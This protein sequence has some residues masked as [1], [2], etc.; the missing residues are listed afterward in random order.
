M[1]E[2]KWASLGM[3]LSETLRC[4]E[5][6]MRAGR[7][8]QVLAVAGRH[9]A[10]CL[11]PIGRR[12]VSGGES[13]PTAGQVVAEQLRDALAE[14]GPTFIKLGQVLSSRPDLLP[15]AFEATLSTLQDSAPAV[16]FEA[17]GAAVRAELGLSPEEVFSCFGH[18]PLAAASI[19]QVHPARLQ[20]GRQVVVKVRRPGVEAL[21]ELDLTILRRLA[22]LASSFPGPAE[23][24]NVAGF[25]EEFGNTTRAELDYL[26][27][28]HNEDRARPQLAPLGVHVPEVVWASTTRAVLTLERI[29]WRQ[30]R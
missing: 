14:L 9:G 5:A 28:G 19:G 10:H 22:R 30:D 21:I 20:D 24:F 3:S 17:I 26:A 7:V 13:K 11:G 15:P 23:Q 25:V 2:S 6:L 1:A 4:S 27:E 18:Q 12:L 16:S 29:L 8:L